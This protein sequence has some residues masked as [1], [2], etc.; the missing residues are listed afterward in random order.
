[1]AEQFS[2]ISLGYEVGCMPPTATFVSGEI[3]LINLANLKTSG[4]T[5]ENKQFIPTSS[6]FNLLRL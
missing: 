6:G 3:D 1:M 2:K 4:N 5:W